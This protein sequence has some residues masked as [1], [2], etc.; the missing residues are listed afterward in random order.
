M[1]DYYA[2]TNFVFLTT[3]FRQEENV[4]DQQK[5]R[6]GHALA[7]IFLPRT[8]PLVPSVTEKRRQTSE[9]KSLRRG[10]FSAAN[11]RL[12]V[13]KL[14]LLLL[15]MLMMVM[16]LV[17]RTKE[18]NSRP[19]VITCLYTAPASASSKQ[20]SAAQLRLNFFIAV[21]VARIASITFRSKY[22]LSY[23]RKL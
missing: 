12:R 20:V 2:D 19:D 4:F 5:F 16:M 14:F 3:V 18:L 23:P 6:R 11:G 10:N 22:R 9:E 17:R 13:F 8:T 1:G 15:Q 21:A 7:F